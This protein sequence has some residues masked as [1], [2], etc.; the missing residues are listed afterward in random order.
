[1]SNIIP[2][3][4]ELEAMHSIVDELLKSGLY[5]QKKGE[6][7]VA[8]THAEAFA[9]VLFGWEI[10]IGA[11]QSMS[12]INIMQGKLSMSAALMTG[13]MTRAGYNWITLAHND[14]E[15]TLLI[16]NA[17]KEELGK[18]TF[19]YK[20]AVDA[21]LPSKNA[22]WKTYRLDM[23]FARCISAA[24]RRYASAVFGGNSVYTPEELGGDDASPNKST[25]SHREPEPTPEPEPVVEPSPEEL[26]KTQH[27][28]HIA[29]LVKKVR[30]TAAL[31]ETDPKKKM[32]LVQTTIN[33]LA[34]EIEEEAPILDTSSGPNFMLDLK[35]KLDEEGLNMLI[36]AL[37]AKLPK[38]QPAKKPKKD[39]E[40]SPK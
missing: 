27:E 30:E 7:Y 1:M 22:N 37:E 10:G 20:Q 16:R 3:G 38:A 28:M 13:L 6:G 29:E 25:Q 39:S 11:A 17:D 8:L 33:E 4:Q 14:D 26:A 24:A 19:T 34:V 12:A 35:N 40:T 21:G 23:L 9:K 32:E 36:S 15:C 2:V 31:I 18:V 5:K